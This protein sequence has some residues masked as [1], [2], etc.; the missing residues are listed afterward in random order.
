[1]PLLPEIENVS[2]NTDT[3]IL[4]Y[5]GNGIIKIFDLKPFLSETSKNH[6]TDIKL[7]QEGATLNDTINISEYDLWATGKFYGWSK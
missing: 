4:V 5:F 3:T 1:M 7:N 2:I 6:P